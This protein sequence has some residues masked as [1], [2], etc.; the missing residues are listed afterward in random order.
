MY[1]VYKPHLIDTGNAIAK[2]VLDEYNKPKGLTDKQRKLFKNGK[3]RDGEFSVLS[4][5]V[6]IKDSHNQD[7]KRRKLSIDDNSY[8][9]ICL[10]TGVK[11][12]P[13]A[14][15]EGKSGRILHDL[16]S[17]ILSLRLFN[18]FILHEIKKVKCGAKSEIIECFE[19]GNEDQNGGAK[20]R[21]IEG[22]KFGMFISEI[23]CGD[24][25][26]ENVKEESIDEWA[27]SNDGILR[28][29]LGFGEL[30]RVRTKPG[31]LDSLISLSKSCSDKLTLIQFKGLLNGVVEDL[32]GFTKLDYLVLPAGKVKIES[33]ERCFWNRFQEKL[34]EEEKLNWGGFHV[35]PSDIEFDK[36]GFDSVGTGKSCCFEILRIPKLNFLQIINNGVKNGC[37]I[38]KIKKNDRSEI[39]RESMIDIR[40][41][42][43]AI[44]S[45]TYNQF[46]KKNLDYLLKKER[47]KEVLGSWG[48]STLD[49]FEICHHI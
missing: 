11:S 2:C 34:T 32:I 38:K 48:E 10:S 8:Q 46:K 43:N 4:G 3:V 37:S 29:R 1:E 20:Y 26:L 42:I 24:A 33:V 23:P 9:L 45:D 36:T 6:M 25:S 30:G 5:I 35:I 31:R 15:I 44:K 28:G 16:H 39:S 14:K 49:D 12:M 41:E 17:E 22:I 47:C 27:V 19:N 40:K 18:Y 7:I 13:V 21:I